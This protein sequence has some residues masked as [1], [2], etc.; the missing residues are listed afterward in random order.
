M[1]WVS[2][3]VE[4]FS[5]SLLASQSILLRATFFGESVRPGAFPFVFTLT[6]TCLP[7][8]TSRGSTLRAA[9]AVDW[10]PNGALTFNCSPV[11]VTAKKI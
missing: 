1:M 11:S 7:Q 8:D 10:L 9:Q 5:C 4:Y 2:V 3:E 6:L